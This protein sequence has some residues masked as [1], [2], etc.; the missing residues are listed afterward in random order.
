M[1]KIAWIVLISIFVIVTSIFANYFLAKSSVKIVPFEEAIF[2]VYGSD[3]KNIDYF[4]IFT[5][6]TSHKE[7]RDFMNGD[8][9]LKFNKD[10]QPSHKLHHMTFE[11]YERGFEIIRSDKNLRQLYDFLIT[12]EIIGLSQKSNIDG[13]IDELAYSMGRDY[14]YQQTGPNIQFIME[15]LDQDGIKIIQ[16]LLN[17]SPEKRKE[18]LEKTCPSLN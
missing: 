9:K 3:L 10:N 11:L 7:T 5:K 14:I 12:E 6:V 1:K 15:D 13:I 17:Y 2:P 16:E 18:I 8:L 4:S